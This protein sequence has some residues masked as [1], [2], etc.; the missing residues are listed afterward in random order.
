VKNV[1]TVNSARSENPA[2]MSI[3]NKV[4][5]GSPL[6]LVRAKRISFEEYHARIL[7]SLTDTSFE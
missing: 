1:N 5:A 6:A 3:S 2:E 4:E 7:L